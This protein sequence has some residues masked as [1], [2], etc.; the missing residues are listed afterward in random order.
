[1]EDH[2]FKQ[3]KDQRRELV[4]VIYLLCERKAYL[5]VGVGV[6]RIVQHDDS[7]SF[8]ELPSTAAPGMSPDNV[9]SPVFSTGLH[10]VLRM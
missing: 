5:P 2:K 7:L 3:E 6:Y 10:F 9:R 1:M 4:P 8:T